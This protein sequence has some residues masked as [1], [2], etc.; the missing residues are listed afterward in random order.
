MTPI[1]LR[2]LRHTFWQSKGHALIA[3][4]SIIADRHDT[5]MFTIA[6]MQQFIPYLSGQTHPLGRRLADIQHC[7][8]TN[9]VEEVGD[10]SHHT[11]FFMM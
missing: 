6:G 4:H 1:Q 11:M 10:N 2:D 8:R 3:P 5:A 7:I 9:D